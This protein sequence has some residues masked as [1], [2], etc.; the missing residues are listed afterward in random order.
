LNLTAIA[1]GRCE[2][3]LDLQE[4]HLQQDGVVHAGVMAT[5]ADHTSGTAG[6]SLIA[7]GAYVLTAEFKIN[8]LEAARGDRLNCI[9]KVLKPGRRLIVAESEVFCRAAAGS[10]LVAK[11]M[12]TLA[13][14][15]PKS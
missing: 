5:M 13:V 4:R 2:T 15:R 1:P 6:A 3:T 7:K 11:A 9:G 14:V 10:R 12:V 8:F